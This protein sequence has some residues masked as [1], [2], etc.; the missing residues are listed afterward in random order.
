MRGPGSYRTEERRANQG[1]FL[2][3]LEDPPYLFVVAVHL[4]N[5]SAKRLAGFDISQAFLGDLGQGSQ[6]SLNLATQV[7]DSSSVEEST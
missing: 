2:A 1:F 5:L 6:V 3:K 4:E 7:P